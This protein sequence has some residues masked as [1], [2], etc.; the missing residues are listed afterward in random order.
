MHEG[1][2][3]FNNVNQIRLFSFDRK[4]RE[5]LLSIYRLGSIRQIELQNTENDENLIF[6]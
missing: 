4:L 1:Y 3:S 6:L 5:S 2:S